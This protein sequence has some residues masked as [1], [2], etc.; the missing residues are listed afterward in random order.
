MTLPPIQTNL[1]HDRKQHASES[2]D[3]YAQE[4]L[5][6]K[7]YPSVQQRTRKAE[8]LGQTILTIPVCGRASS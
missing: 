7:A 8:A 3:A 5:F 6:H 4:P 1:L 2:V